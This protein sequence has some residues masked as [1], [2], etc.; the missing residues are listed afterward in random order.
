[1]I[2][3]L[4]IL[5][6]LVS[7]ARGWAGEAPEKPQTGPSAEVQ[8]RDGS[9][10][11]LTILDP[12]L[13]VMTRFGALTVPTTEIRRI[14]FGLRYPEG[15]AEKIEGAVK[16][17]GDGD[18]KA[19]ESA[20]AELRSYREWAYPALMGATRSANAEVAKRAKELLDEL[21]QRVPDIDAAMNENDRVT[22]ADFPIVGR[23]DAAVL[24]GHS[25]LLGN[26]VVRLHQAK[27]LRFSGASGEVS[28]KVNAA[29]HGTMTNPWLDTGVDVSSGMKLTITATGTV[30]LDPNNPGQTVVNAQGMDP[31]AA[32]G[33]NLNAANRVIIFANQ[34]G[35]INPNVAG[36]RPNNAMTPNQGALVG[37]IGN[38]QWFLVGEKYTGTIRESGRLQLS[39]VNFGNNMTGGFSV[40]I[41]TE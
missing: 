18:F 16:K 39:I 13:K 19:R 22:T 36:I 34:F 23:I 1:M 26:V 28:V 38:G 9:V 17:L 7:S 27:S 8:F 35:P 3:G 2:R 33:G 6:A 30:D 10:V 25:P 20:T 41:K 4:L 31:R 40:S 15:L 14:D 11:K 21:R 24:R 12:E 29:E 5:T 32:Q 37:R